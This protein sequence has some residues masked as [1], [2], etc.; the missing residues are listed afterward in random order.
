MPWLRLTTGHHLVDLE[1][2]VGGHLDLA[3][4]GAGDLTAAEAAFASR[5][6]HLDPRQRDGR[7]PDLRLPRGRAVLEQRGA[8]SVRRAIRL[9]VDVLESD[10]VHIERQWYRVGRPDALEEVAAGGVEAKAERF[11]RHDQRVAGE[12]DGVGARRMLETELRAAGAARL[13]DVGDEQDDGVTVVVDHQHL[14]AF[15]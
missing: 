11:D 6:R 13:G 12:V 5:Y 7:A 15:E 8:E 3:G 4:V 10:A 9:F 2:R 1:T 14:A